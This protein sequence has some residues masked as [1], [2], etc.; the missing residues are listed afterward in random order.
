MHWSLTPE[1]QDFLYELYTLLHKSPLSPHGRYRTFE[2]A[3][4]DIQPWHIDSISTKALEHLVTTGKAKG[5]R[6]GHRLARKDRAAHMFDATKEM[7]RDE[8][9][10]Y[11]YKNDVVTVITAEENYQDGD[12]HW[13]SLVPVPIER[14][15]GGTYS[16]YATK[17][18]IAWAA[19]ELVAHL[20]KA[21]ENE[22][23]TNEDGTDR[24]K[25]N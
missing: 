21:A 3:A 17:A 14:L 8:M 19:Q 16:M 7:S 25:A 11:F 2:T 1:Q 5:L 6:R 4:V 9:L 18:D 22:P 24:S 15:K 13:S 23:D 20:A 10:T 12:E